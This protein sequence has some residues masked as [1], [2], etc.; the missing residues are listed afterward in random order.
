MVKHHRWQHRNR[1]VSLLG[2][3]L[4]I[5]LIGVIALISIT[6]IGSTKR[7]IFD[8]V[9]GQIGDVA[10]GSTQQST[11]ALDPGSPPPVFNAVDTSLLN[12]QICGIS[13]GLPLRAPVS[14]ALTAT[15]PDHDANE[16]T[17]QLAQGESL[18][19][20]LTLAANGLLSGTPTST[21][22]DTVTVEVVDPT[23]QSDSLDL[24][25]TVFETTAP[26]ALVHYSFDDADMNG[27]QILNTQSSLYFANPTGSQPVSVTG[28][29]GQARQFSDDR[30]RIASGFQTPFVPPVGS[31]V[32]ISVWFDGTTSGVFLGNNE[33]GSNSGLWIRQNLVAQSGGSMSNSAS[34]SFSGL[35]VP[36]GFF[37]MVIALNRVTGSQNDTIS[38]WVDC[39]LVNE[40]PLQST[41]NSGQG[42]DFAFNTSD[43]LILGA[44]RD[45]TPSSLPFSGTIDEMRILHGSPDAATVRQ[46]YLT[47]RY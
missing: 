6:G 34:T 23:G 28:I 14:V 19:A 32:L 43:R 5:G 12:P 29:Q 36:S 44:R 45:T 21:F 11:T 47:D 10:S 22:S 26:S 27:A 30:A 35:S 20:G 2:Y 16:L 3:G 37:H 1:G 40:Y 33:D 13:S 9:G 17:Y 24:P 41:V 4:L 7:G 31:S 15:D 38:V 46:L 18:P 25:L 8:L 42:R 39:E